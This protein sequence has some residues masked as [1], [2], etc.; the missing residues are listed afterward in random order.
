[1]LTFPVRFV[2]LL[3]WCCLFVVIG[4]ERVAIGLQTDDPNNAAIW[5][6]RAIEQASSI[7]PDQMELI[8]DYSSVGGTPSP[9]VRR[10][11]EQYAPT[12]A[13]I[14]R[15]A[16]KPYS[17]YGLN[18]DDGI[19]MLLPHLGEIR[20]LARIVKAD[21]KMK[22][23]DGNAGG[24][25][26]Q[27]ASLYRLADH[28]ADDHML[29]SSLVGVAVF[30]LTDDLV[31][32]GFEQAA[33]SP[34]ESAILLQA[35][36][37]YDQRDPFAAVDALGA[38]SYL[39]TATLREH[40]EN[41][42]M[43]S[44]VDLSEFFGNEAGNLEPLDGMSALDLKNELDSYD[45][46]MERMVGVFANEDSDAARAEL[47]EIEQGIENGDF[48]LFASLLAP[49][50]GRCYENMDKARA[51]LHGRVESL[52][53][54]LAGQLDTHDLA[55][56]AVWYR[57][58]IKKLDGLDPDW[59]RRLVSFDPQRRESIQDLFAPLS[60]DDQKMVD[61][62]LGEF[63]A[64]S[65]IRKC[66]FS[67]HRRV[68]ETII[69]SYAG[70]MRDGMTLLALD[71]LRLLGKGERD[72]AAQRLAACF[73]VTAHLSDDHLLLSS[74]VAQDA[75]QL[76]LQI[77]DVVL[78]VTVTSNESDAPANDL[79]PGRIAE[80]AS[81]VGRMS[82]T[83][84]FG[85]IATRVDIDDAAEK[86]MNWFLGAHLRSEA[87]GESS[88]ELT[89]EEA[90]EGALGWISDRSTAQKWYFL[91]TASLRFAED[92][93]RVMERFKT[94]AEAF[95]DLALPV[96]VDLLAIDAPIV[97]EICKSGTWSQFALPPSLG[98]LEIADRARRAK[99]LERIGSR[100]IESWA[101]LLA[102][103]DIASEAPVEVGT[104]DQ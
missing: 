38:E 75:Y 94:D 22:L 11:L 102:A 5:Y 3:M 9:E 71:A 21:V 69:P 6:R 1:M 37:A 85:F 13:H 10:I 97:E 74:I 86:R 68:E 73:R 41:A 91:G 103:R 16:A 26:T 83:D 23:A 17:D 59:R 84:P 100:L 104:P 64:G 96:I 40:F 28:T 76:L 79:A 8:Q 54:H 89:I 99:Q 80:L 25:A 77:S 66:D 65:L 60:Q 19:F 44:I 50:L 72:A 45:Q 53:K 93:Q 43:E 35:V 27:I 88:D 47:K 58:G 55:N 20:N 48:G 42:D 78:P 62:A 30:S 32:Y 29:I 18:F 70:G 52:E 36:R 87:A 46:L 51:M 81:S 67:R 2:H 7:T 49:A 33:F 14:Q 92:E 95:G 34:A 82:R 39:V 12:L 63:I 56:A 57:R 101:S 24:A 98:E 90:R 4:N 61:E 31:D 15:G